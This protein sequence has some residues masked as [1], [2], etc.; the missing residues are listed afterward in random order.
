MIQKPTPEEDERITRAAIDD[1]DAQPLSDEQLM[2]MVP[3]HSLRGRPRSTNRKQ[4]VSIRYSPE[5]LQ[6]FKASGSG[7]QSRMDAVLKDYVEHHS[8]G[9][10]TNSHPLTPEAPAD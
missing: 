3:L 5:V 4:L 10:N 7:W 2:A 9:I 8:G 6:F 1:Q